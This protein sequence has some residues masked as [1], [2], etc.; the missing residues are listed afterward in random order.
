MSWFS[1]KPERTE[2]VQ[3]KFELDKTR[4]D[5]F[6]SEIDL[7]TKGQMLP[8]GQDDTLK[9]TYSF[10]VDYFGNIVAAFK[11]IRTLLSDRWVVREVAINEL[12]HG[13]SV[14]VEL[15]DEIRKV[16]ASL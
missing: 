1:Q 5:K 3:I 11:A 12:K 2:R 13:E 8:T 7:L 14:L 16:Q 15:L 10:G 6:K 9:L 4:I